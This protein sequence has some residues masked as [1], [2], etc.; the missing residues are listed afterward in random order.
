ME[1]NIYKGSRQ[2]DHYLFLPVDK[3]VTEIP[4]DILKMFGDIELVMKLNISRST[5]LAQSNPS[6]V[7]D[8]INEKGF[9]IQLPPKNINI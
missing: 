6:D 9:Y 4:G 8:I 2:Q 5:R 1:C 3:S 7:I